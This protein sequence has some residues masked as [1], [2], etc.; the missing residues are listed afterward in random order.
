MR[1]AEKEFQILEQMSSTAIVLEFKDEILSLIDKFR[2]SEQSGASAPYVS[3]IIT[4]TITNLCNHKPITPLLG[5]ESEWNNNQNLRDSAVFRNDEDDV[6]E[7][8]G[9]IIWQDDESE[10]SFTGWCYLDEDC[11]I[12]ISSCQ[13]IKLPIIP[14]SFHV[15]VKRIYVDAKFAE[16]SDIICSRDVD[17]FGIKTNDYYYT[18][19]DDVEQLL[20]P[21]DYFENDELIELVFLKMEEGSTDDLDDD[22]LV[23]DDVLV[24]GE[25]KKLQTKVN[26]QYSY[27]Q[28]LFKQIKNLVDYS[29]VQTSALND[30]ID[31][32]RKLEDKTT[33]QDSLILR[34]KIEKL[35]KYDNMN[36]NKSCSS[37]DQIKIFTDFI[38][39]NNLTRN[40]SSTYRDLAQK[41]LKDDQFSN[42]IYS[43]QYDDDMLFFSTKEDVYIPFEIPNFVLI[44]DS[45]TAVVR[46]PS[47]ANFKFNNILRTDDQKI[48]TLTLYK[49]KECERAV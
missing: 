25:I 14:K 29:D 49:N 22:E 44:I 10:T 11:E 8:N 1:H 45:S 33:S 40:L 27:S 41:T 32:V 26:E 2:N 35:S 24:H 38:H 48:D 42:L 3:A 30:T 13:P 31:D 5:Y 39:I 19:V 36:F 28:Y 34:N 4:N 7:L 18:V 20:E 6:I 16:E 37:Y 43:T 21:L 46:T 15:D 23:E 9:A 17:E 47:D 12:M